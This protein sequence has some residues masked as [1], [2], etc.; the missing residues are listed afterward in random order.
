MAKNRKT[1]SVVPDPLSARILSQGGGKRPIQRPTPTEGQ[2]PFNPTIPSR[3]DVARD[4]RS[5]SAGLSAEAQRGAIGDPSRMSTNQRVGRA[6]KDAGFEGNFVA[7]FRKDAEEFLIESEITNQQSP[8]YKNP[9][10][11]PEPGEI[12][13]MA[14]DMAMRKVRAQSN[15]KLRAA[16]EIIVNREFEIERGTAIRPERSS[17]PRVGLVGSPKSDSESTKARRLAEAGA[18]ARERRPYDIVLEGTTDEV[19]REQTKRLQAAIDEGD[20]IAYARELRKFEQTLATRMVQDKDHSTA[21]SDR[22]ATSDQ[23]TTSREEAGRN[24][25]DDGGP[26]KPGSETE[27]KVATPGNIKR[28]PGDIT[29]DAFDVIASDEAELNKFL[30]RFNEKDRAKIMRELARIDKD[31][32]SDSRSMA[33][34]EYLKSIDKALSIEG[35]VKTETKTGVNNPASRRRAERLAT[36]PRVGRIEANEEGRSKRAS[37]RAI[38]SVF[39]DRVKELNA[40]REN[41]SKTSG[42]RHERGS[43]NARS[44]TNAKNFRAALDN[45]VSIFQSLIPT[46]LGPKKVKR[47]LVDSFNQ[48]GKLEQIISALKGVLNKGEFR[49]G[50]RN[51][52]EEMSGRS[53]PQVDAIFSGVGSRIRGGPSTRAAR[54][55]IPGIP[56]QNE[57]SPPKSGRSGRSDAGS[58]PPAKVPE[59]AKRPEPGTSGIP[60][61]SSL[62]RAIDEYMETINREA[63][64]MRDRKFGTP[65]PKVSEPMKADDY[66]RAGKIMATRVRELTESLTDELRKISTNKVP[67]VIKDANQLESAKKELKDLQDA[68]RE[69]RKTLRDVVRYQGVTRRKIGSLEKPGAVVDASARI[70]VENQISQLEGIIKRLEENLGLYGKAIATGAKRLGLKD[71]DI[72]VAVREA[73]RA[74]NFPDRVK[75]GVPIGPSRAKPAP[76]KGKPRKAVAVPKGYVR[77]DRPLPEM[78]ARTIGDSLADVREVTGGEF[79]RGSREKPGRPMSDAR[80]RA[81]KSL[82]TRRRIEIIR[83]IKDRK[84][85]NRGNDRARIRDNEGLA[86]LLEGIDV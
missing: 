83:S 32:N 66:E 64:L 11:R 60:T 21:G 55:G 37:I 30:S 28:E 57:T 5:R 26:Q 79:N 35:Q 58:Q 23:R 8:N 42:F 59:G 27:G 13:A 80:K 40:T 62:D 78:F 85:G 46:G 19:L 76:K 47:V 39:E 54:A 9:R 41:L 63:V 70:D 45:A 68:I 38:L 56:T 71:K 67:R 17:R 43:L 48:P 44:R 12:K 82:N 72:Q 24:R 15:P 31:P 20:E 69:G 1:K 49:P 77:S 3:G 22:T 86:K 14:Y 34:G 18:A 36:L 50:G 75:M 33:K 73:E 61:S 65:L 81:L 74:S 51:I 53:M 16:L 10:W 2:A 4:E 6:I 84:S 7:K 52:E 29:R 25:Y